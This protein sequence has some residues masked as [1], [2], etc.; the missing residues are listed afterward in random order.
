MHHFNVFNHCSFELSLP[1]VHSLSLSLN[2]SYFILFLFLLDVPFFI[3]HA[4]TLPQHYTRQ[5]VFS[6]TILLLLLHVLPLL[7][8]ISGNKSAG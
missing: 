6:V 5:S 2:S 4:T 1:A 8:R 3:F 7:F